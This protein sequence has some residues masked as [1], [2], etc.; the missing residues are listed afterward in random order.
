MDSDSL[1]GILAFMPQFSHVNHVGDDILVP[2]I[3]T[4]FRKA[5]GRVIETTDTKCIVCMWVMLSKVI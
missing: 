3:H 1:G 5:W 4:R 2:I